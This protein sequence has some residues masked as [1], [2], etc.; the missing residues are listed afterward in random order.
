M[1]LNPINQDFKLTKRKGGN[2]KIS[3]TIKHHKVTGGRIKNTVNPNAALFH[4]S[5][6]T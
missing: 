5:A 4:E 1:S 6:K 3:T 2:S